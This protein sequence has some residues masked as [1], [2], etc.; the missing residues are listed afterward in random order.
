MERLSPV[1]VIGAGS[2]GTTVAAI[3]ADNGAETRLWCRRPELAGEINQGRCSPDYLPDIRLPDGVR[4]TPSLEEAVSG[5]PLVVV[6]VPSHAFRRVFSLAAGHLEP[7]VS[8][9][10]LAKGVEQE[11]LKRMTEVVLE[12]APRVDPDRVGVLTG[13]NLARELACRQPAASVVAMADTETAELVQRTF[14]TGYLRVYTNPDVVG[15][16]IAGACKNVMAIAAGMCDGMALGDNAKAALITRGLNELTRLGLA[17]GGRPIT[18]AGLAG[19]GDLVATCMSGTSRN[20]HVGEELGR[21]RKIDDI[22]AEMSMVAEGVKSTRAII[23]LAGRVG[24]EMPIAEQVAK[25]LYQGVDPRQV[26]LSLMG[27]AP[28]P[29]WEEGDVQ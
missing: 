6:G 19:V 13:P 27:R 2:W 10:S 11:S 9:V 3:A 1:A 23:D 8:V 18:F 25:V 29:E 20:R 28:T 5:A 22:C 12:E 17:L 14:M 26:V 15:S 16:E 21:G 4:A 24:V 7:E